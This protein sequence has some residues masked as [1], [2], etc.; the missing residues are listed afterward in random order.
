MISR[1][2]GETHNLFKNFKSYWGEG[3]SIHCTSWK[4]VSDLQETETT[5]NE[6]VTRKNSGMEKAEAIFLR[7][8]KGIK[9]N[10]VKG[11]NE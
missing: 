5:W 7:D 6:E 3:L 2:W 1:I 4:T 11:G 8:L 9:S 10:R